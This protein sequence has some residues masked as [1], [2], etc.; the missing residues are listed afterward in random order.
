[1][2][3]VLPEGAAVADM[4]CGIGGDSIALA[5]HFSVT[6]LDLDEARL[7]F[8]EANCVAN[9]HP[10]N[11]YA[12]DITHAV[13]SKYAAI[14]FDPARRTGEGKR[15]FS[16][17]AYRPPLSTI[18]NWLAQVPNIVVKISPGVDYTEL[19]EY[20][21]EVEIISE[22]GDVKEAVLW[23]GAFKTAERR[24]TLLPAAHTLT[25]KAD[26]LPIAVGAP[27]QYLYE[28]DGAVI[29]AGL[30]EELAEQMGGTTRKLDEDIAFLTSEEC[31]ATPF[32]RRFTIVESQPWNLKKLNRRLQELEV[33]RVVVKK[34]GSPVDPQQ[35]EHALKLKGQREMTVV[36]THVM[37]QPFVLLCGE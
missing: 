35:L 20:A 5:T 30:V 26:K 3:Q 7:T 34:R 11:F 14:F 33:G 19:A 17:E 29:R 32:A 13:V 25:Y 6:G 1:M 12:E 24:A 10:A 18:R 37:G 2:R 31:H 23:F 15:L 8:A 16:V 9:G 21:C 22:N 4:C 36:L 28:P 27:L